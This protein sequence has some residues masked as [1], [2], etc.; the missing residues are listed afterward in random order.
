[1]TSDSMAE[2][3]SY[4]N[5]SPSLYPKGEATEKFISY[6]H[7]RPTTPPLPLV[8]DFDA[9]LQEV[10]CFGNFVLNPS[11][12]FQNP[13]NETLSMASP[14]LPPDFVRN[15]AL[16]VKASP[17]SRPGKVIM[18]PKECT[19]GQRQPH[20]Q[21]QPQLGKSLSTVRPIG[22]AQ[23]PSLPCLGL[24]STSGDSTLRS[25]CSISP[26]SEETRTLLQDVVCL[27]LETVSWEAALV[28]NFPSKE[29]LDH[30]ID[31]YFHH[32]DNVS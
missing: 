28:A 14:S 22:H 29:K 9:L 13:E 6:P 17:P 30:C 19:L 24:S 2:A 23:Q 26:L 15:G 27:R 16:P 21:S 8:N 3:S 4:Q 25:F 1:M 11:D 20:T 7:Y 18:G 32:A 12:F 10:S 31:L 5:G